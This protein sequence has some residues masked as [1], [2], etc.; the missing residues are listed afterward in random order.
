MEHTIVHFEIPAKSLEKSKKFHQELFGWKFSKY[1][2]EGE[3]EPEYWMMTT[4]ASEK[5]GRPLKAGVNGDMY[6]M[7]TPENKSMNYITLSPRT[8]IY[9]RPRIWA[10]KSI[11]KKEIPNID[12]VGAD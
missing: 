3:G 10:E 2:G 8:T 9:R 4:G 5:N 11:K 1:P 7:Q 12:L 6:T